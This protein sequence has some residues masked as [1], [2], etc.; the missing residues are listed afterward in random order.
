MAQIQQQRQLYSGESATSSG[1]KSV[2]DRR[3]LRLMQH[4][5][6]DD[7]EERLI[8]VCSYAIHSSESCCN[9]FILFWVTKHQKVCH[10]Q[11]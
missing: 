2:E 10:I 3:L 1:M 5:Q 11:C 8:A 4:G 7:V 9:Y 6:Q